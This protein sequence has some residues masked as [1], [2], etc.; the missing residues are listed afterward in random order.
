VHVGDGM[1][2]RMKRHLLEHTNENSEETYKDVSSMIRKGLKKLITILSNKLTSAANAS[3]SKM[4]RGLLQMIATAGVRQDTI[5]PDPA[6]LEFQA[7]V[8]GELEGLQPDWQKD[9]EDPSVQLKAVNPLERFDHDLE[10]DDDGEDEDENDE[11]ESG[12]EEGES[13]AEASDEDS[14]SENGE[15]DYGDG[16][17]D[18]DDDDNL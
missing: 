10:G 16:D 6:R 8:L 11:S 5:K 4:R 1:G 9:M 7:S 14:D 2:K 18:E 17:E 3:Q 13:G 12:G 15:D